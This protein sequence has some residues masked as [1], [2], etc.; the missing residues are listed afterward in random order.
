MN[1]ILV[2]VF[3]GSIALCLVSLVLSFFQIRELNAKILQQS[4]VNQEL[5]YR[6]ASIQADLSDF[7]NGTEAI[8]E[9]A[10]NQ[11]GMIKN[12]EIFVQVMDEPI[13]EIVPVHS[14]QPP[15]AQ[16]QNSQDKLLDSTKNK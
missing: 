15:E 12:G 4:K 14:I 1:T 16:I 2:R 7:Q 5:T 13:S 9:R 11:L 10:R 3:L 6:N 8:Y